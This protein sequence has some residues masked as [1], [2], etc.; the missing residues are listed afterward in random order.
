[1]NLNQPNVS[2]DA[3]YL[4]RASCAIVAMGNIA[5]LLDEYDRRVRVANEY[6]NSQVESA[7]LA[8]GSQLQNIVASY[9]S[10]DD[11]DSDEE[12]NDD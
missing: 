3:K 2:E 5:T 12:D 10:L 4:A 7:M 9:R 6:R 8:L 1:M 11:D